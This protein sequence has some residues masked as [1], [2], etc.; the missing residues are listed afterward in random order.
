MWSK[1][2]RAWVTS[3]GVRL[4][5]PRIPCLECAHCP[6]GE[7]LVVEQGGKVSCR[8]RQEMSFAR[9]NN[10]EVVSRDGVFIMGPSSACGPTGPQGAT[11]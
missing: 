5:K 6:R 9:E 2:L 8:A 3:G 4:P 10:C 11:K 7:K 1:G